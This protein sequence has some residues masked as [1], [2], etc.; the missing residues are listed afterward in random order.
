MLK[1]TTI[2]SVNQ[3]GQALF[4]GKVKKEQESMATSHPK[5]KQTSTNTA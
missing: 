2:G 5:Q 1:I 3:D 4:C